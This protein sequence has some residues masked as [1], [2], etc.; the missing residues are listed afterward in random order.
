M[1]LNNPI[2]KA[3]RDELRTVVKM[4]AKLAHKH[5]DVRKTELLADVEAKLAAEYKIDDSVWRDLTAEAQEVVRKADEELARRC[6]ERGIPASFRPGLTLGWYSRGENA[7]EK[8]RK[9]LRLVAQTKI[10]SMAQAARL[11]IETKAVDALELLAQHGITSGEGR[12]L[13]Q[14][15][16]TVK[17]LMPELDIKALGPLDP[18]MLTGSTEDEDEDI[19][20]GPGD[21]A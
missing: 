2:P 9:E 10:E 21:A 11:E 20:I 16:P 18:L 8:R 3:E 7:Y 1:N 19:E 5:I 6:R 12:E 4:R 15:I 13:L 17:E 14:S